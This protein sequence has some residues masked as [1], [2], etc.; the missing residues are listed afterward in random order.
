MKEWK[1]IRVID[2]LSTPF[3]FNSFREVEGASSC[4]IMNLY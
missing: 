2:R 1:R 4:V 3:I